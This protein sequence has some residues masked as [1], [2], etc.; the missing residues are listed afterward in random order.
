MES[1]IPVINK[2]QD[3]FGAIGQRSIDLP[4]ITVVGSQ[5]TGK[6][7]VLEGIVGRDFLPRGNGVVTR[8]PLVLQLY[9]IPAAKPNPS[10]KGASSSGTP[11]E[12]CNGG[13]QVATY[14]AQGEEWGE[15]L[16]IPGKRFYDFDEIRAGKNNVEFLSFRCIYHLTKPIL[17]LH[18]SLLLV[19]FFP[20]N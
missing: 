2:L 6:S 12:G 4:Q 5:S 3:V 19:L 9:N 14:Q 16:H 11:G 20:R 18:I 7:S 8:R 10:N 1:L 13:K 17:A 15:F